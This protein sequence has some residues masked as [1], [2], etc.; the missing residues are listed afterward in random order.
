MDEDHVHPPVAEVVLV[1]HM[2]VIWQQQV[3]AWLKLVATILLVHV[4]QGLGCWEADKQVGVLLPL[5][6][7]SHPA[8]PAERTIITVDC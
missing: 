6:Q 7:D 8:S 1:L 2:A 4:T 3:D 5:C